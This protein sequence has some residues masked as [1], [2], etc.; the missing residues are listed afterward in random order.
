MNIT[1]DELFKWIASAAEL[2]VS[3]WNTEHR[4]VEDHMA[5]QG[6]DPE[7]AM[8]IVEYLPVAFSDHI[9][10]NLGVERLPD[11]RRTLTDGS[12]VWCRWLDD[13]VYIAVLHYKHEYAASRWDDYK[14]IAGTCADVQSANDALTAGKEI[15]GGRSSIH[16]LG[17]LAPD[18]PWLPDKRTDT[19][20][21]EASEQ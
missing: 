6:C 7:L 5:A 9:M 10:E 15:R 13:P 20:P 19:D 14:K 2:W 8:I 16:P 18:S 11:Y 3:D 12:H 17:F 4:A 21:N 1:H